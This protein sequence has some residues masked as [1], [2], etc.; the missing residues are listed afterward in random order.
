VS[1][2]PPDLVSG[3]DRGS[4]DCPVP[5]DVRNASGTMTRLADEQQQRRDEGQR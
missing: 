4:Y 5:S 3:G 2:G 1:Q